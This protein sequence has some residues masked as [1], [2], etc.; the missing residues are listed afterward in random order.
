MLLMG[1]GNNTAAL[2]SILKDVNENNCGSENIEDAVGYQITGVKEIESD[3]DEF[4]SRTRNK[5]KPLLYSMVDPDADTGSY[6]KEPV[7]EDTEGMSVCRWEAVPPKLYKPL[8]LP[9][10]ERSNIQGKVV[11]FVS[12]EAIIELVSAIPK[13]KVASCKRISAIASFIY[14]CLYKFDSIEAE[15]CWF[16]YNE[17]YRHDTMYI[18]HNHRVVTEHGEICG[19]GEVTGRCKTFRRRNDAEVLQAEGVPT[20]D[21]SYRCYVNY[22]KQYQYDFSDLFIGI[23]EA[24]PYEEDD[25]DDDFD[26]DDE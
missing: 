14:S 6:I 2:A 18:M 26:E 13:G 11:G 21:N 15:S 10:L 5:K 23:R 12:P 22:L 24:R 4:E 8:L 1:S 17:H 16:D 3:W 20:Y 9:P 19:N 25:S 7:Y